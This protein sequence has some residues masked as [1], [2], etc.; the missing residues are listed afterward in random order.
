MIK[1]GSSVLLNQD[2]SVAINRLLTIGQAVDKLALEHYSVILVVSG[3]VSHG[4]HILGDTGT[5]TNSTCAAVGQPV[6]LDAVSM[7]LKSETIPLLVSPANLPHISTLLKDLCARSYIP[8]VNENDAM[9]QL[10]PI[11]DYSLRDNDDLASQLAVSL[12]AQRLIILTDVDGVKT[13]DGAIIQELNFKSSK[14]V[15]FND[16]HTGKGGMGSKVQACLDAVK[17]GVQ[18][19]V[20]GNGHACPDN[21]HYLPGTHFHSKNSFVRPAYSNGR[22]ITELSFDQRL[23]LVKDILQHLPCDEL[24]AANAADMA[25]HPNQSRLELTPDKLNTV[26]TG[27]LD[28]LNTI[29]DPLNEVREERT[30]PNG[31]ML[32]KVTCPLGTL[33]VIFEARPDAIP[34]IVSLALITGNKLRLKGGSEA[35]RTNDMIYRKI[36]EVFVKHKVRFNTLITYGT[37]E[38]AQ[39]MLQSQDIDLLIPR[40]SAQLIAWVRAH[41]TVPVLAHADGVCHIYV[42]ININLEA[43][44]D[45][46]INAKLQYPSACNA[47]EVLL[48]HQCWYNTSDLNVLLY[49]LGKAGIKLQAGPQMS[50]MQPDWPN[51]PDFHIEYGNECLLVEFVSDVDDAIRHINTHSSHHT[52]SILSTDTKTIDKFVSGVD[53]ACVFANLSTRFADGQRLGLG[54]EVGISTSRIHAR[55][56]VGIDGLLTTKYIVTSDK[57]QMVA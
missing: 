4:R 30:L 46:I 14:R 49:Q 26:I 50:T 34:Q 22:D 55:G 17:H 21:L 1:L 10:S 56:P 25:A 8:V 51:T 6:I 53:S 18:S 28:Y 11:P 16:D 33:G 54:A 52:D 32:R 39:R 3:A 41:A 45:V 9:T 42:D 37:R 13:P 40:G 44:T 36:Y 7:S 12:R 2:G 43:I 29:E 23:A 57:L 5:C 19:A 27:I 24:F 15:V 31:A 35:E 47:V 38:E 48:L 20:I